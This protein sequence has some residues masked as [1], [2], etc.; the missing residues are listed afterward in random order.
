MQQFRYYLLERKFT[1]LCD[2]KP[3]LSFY[4]GK[5][6][7]TPR[8]EKHIVANQDLDFEMKYIR[9]KDNPTDWN[10]RHPESLDSWSQRMKKKSSD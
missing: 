5:K 9:G 8:M 4:N 10:S 6:K 7:T 3:L 2:H 1:T